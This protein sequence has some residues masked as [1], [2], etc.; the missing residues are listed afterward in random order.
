MK[1]AGGTMRLALQQGETCKVVLEAGSTVL[2]L[3]GRAQ[4]RM[5]PAWMAETTVHRACLLFAEEAWVAESS[6]SL[7]LLAIEELVAVILPAHGVSF[8]RRV[9]RCLERVFAGASSASAAPSAGGKLA[10]DG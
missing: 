4:L 1:D 2:L 5:P 6:G 8:W 7:D 10:S 9:G 3:S